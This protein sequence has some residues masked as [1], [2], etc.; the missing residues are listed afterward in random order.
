MKWCQWRQWARCHGGVDDDDEHG[1]EVS[2]VRVE[3]LAAMAEVS[4]ARAE[5]LGVNDDKGSV[6]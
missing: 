2:T 5:M 6:T 4:T 3:V 1:Q